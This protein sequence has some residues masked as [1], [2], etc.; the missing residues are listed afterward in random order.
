MLATKCKYHKITKYR[1]TIK[2]VQFHR[3]VFF[4]FFLKIKKE[5][6]FGVS[7]SVLVTFVIRKSIVKS[8][9]IHFGK[10]SDSKDE[11]TV[12]SFG[13]KRER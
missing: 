3:K 11:D 1:T 2:F 8:F 10:L 13:A 12:G 9:D 5:S 4:F 7:C 6:G